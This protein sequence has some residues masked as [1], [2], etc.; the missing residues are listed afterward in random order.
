[1][2]TKTNRLWAIA[3]LLV[4]GTSFSACLKSVDTKPSRPIAAFT[5]INGI[6]SSVAL[7]FFDNDTAKAIGTKLPMGFVD[8]NYQAYGG[9]HQFFF[10]K[11]GT[12]T[13]KIASSITS[14]DSLT[15]YTIVA[16]GDSSNAVI[17]PIKDDFSSAVTT[18]LN[19]RFFN[20]SPNMPPVD[21]FIG[22]I[23]VDSNLAYVGTSPAS[24]AFKALSTVSSGSVIRVKLTGVTPA[25]TIAETTTA[26]L[27]S[28]QVYT[29]FLTGLKDNVGPLKP[30]VN[31]IESYY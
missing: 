12:T 22:D 4:I 25:I 30:K 11:T 2:A 7:D 19:M 18:K 28:G 1:M 21:L 31:Y 26:N 20:L 16:Y 23:K 10:T 13:P 9:I 24:T 8:N 6:V 15:F 14:Y 3:A 27:A 17:R 29:I 5:V